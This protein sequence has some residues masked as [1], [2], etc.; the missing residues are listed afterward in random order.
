VG[1]GVFGLGALETVDVDPVIGEKEYEADT[2]GV[3]R[4]KGKSLTSIYRGLRALSGWVKSRGKAAIG[5][6]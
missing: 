6:H 1:K 5:S 4:A 2:L 3:S